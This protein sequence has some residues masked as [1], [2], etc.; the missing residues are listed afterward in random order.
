M[1]MTREEVIER[2]RVIRTR[3]KI[4]VGAGLLLAV[5]L[6][7]IAKAIAASMG[8]TLGGDVGLALGMSVLLAVVVASLVNWRCPACRKYLSSPQPPKWRWDACPR[9]GVALR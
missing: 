8:A 9:C 7:F 5:C 4:I 6:P 3:M 2:F 1:T